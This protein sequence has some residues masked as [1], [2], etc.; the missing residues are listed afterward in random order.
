MMHMKTASLELPLR[1]VLESPPPGVDFGLQEGKGN[2][3]TTIQT[4]RSSTEDLRFTF[5]VTVRGLRKDGGPH[6]LGSLS[7]GPPAGRFIY[8]DVGTCAGQKNT[9]WSR[10]I[11]VPLAGITTALV[12]KVT[13]QPKLVL[14]A[15]I[16][17]TGRDGGPSC[18]T[19]KPLNGWCV[20]RA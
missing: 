10:R 13:S 15:R 4:Q 7:Q 8:I 12:K 6:F 20:V 3:Y 19:V 9:C 11:K 1:I 18:A 16:P 5:T 14:E 17:G 2:D